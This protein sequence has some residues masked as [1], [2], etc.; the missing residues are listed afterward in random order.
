MSSD[1]NNF[2][3]IQTSTDEAANQLLPQFQMMLNTALDQQAAKY[4]NTMKQLAE[5]LKLFRMN[6]TQPPPAAAPSAPPKKTNQS[7]PPKKYD[8]RQTRR[9][10]AVATTLRQQNFRRA[11]SE[12][13]AS[14]CL[15]TTPKKIAPRGSLKNGSPSKRAPHQ[16]MLDD[17]PDDFLDTKASSIIFQ[18]KRIIE[19]ST[20]PPPANLEFVQQ[21]CSH[22]QDISAF[23]RHV[24]NSASAQL[25]A[26]TDVQTMKDA[27]A[28]RI[29]VGNNFVHIDETHIRYMHGY[30]AR[31]GIR[32]WGPNLEEGPESLFNSACRISAL[33]TFRQMA[34][35][36]G[37]DFMNF[38]HKYV[39]DMARFIN[40]YNHYVHHLS[41]HKFL[42]EI[43]Q[44]GKYKETVE[45]KNIA[46]NR[47]RVSI[48]ISSVHFMISVTNFIF[49]QLRDARYK[50]AVANNLPE[51]YR[52]IIKDTHANSDD[53]WDAEAKCFSIRTLPYR[54]YSANIFFRRL[55]DMMKN[56]KTN[57]NASRMRARKLPED[58]ILSKIVKIPKSLP[59]DFYNRSWLRKLPISQ[60]TTLPDITQVA[61][62]SDP[63]KS[64]LPKNNPRHDPSEKLS[65]RQFSK[66]RLQ[67]VLMTYRLDDVEEE[68]DDEAEVSEVD[69]ESEDQIDEC[70]AGDLEVG[71]SRHLADGD[72]ESYYKKDDTDNEEDEEYGDSDNH[73]EEMLDEEMDQDDGYENYGGHHLNDAEEEEIHDEDQMF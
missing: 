68:D 43:K 11:Q 65:D 20:P 53:E 73:E 1:N 52:K 23:E 17:Y 63:K 4:E 35:S 69:F 67:E 10:E 9:A 25:I 19:V 40:A 36:G 28:G 55:E 62:L 14:V 22:F 3:D 42:A 27:R 61:F 7:V 72:W 44:P 18:R 21:F 33:N 45:A 60:Q 13:L 38:N 56:S 49:P 57:T 50:F 5:E 24:N 8:T 6:S 15:V 31:I 54:S 41:S 48:Q 51:R 30:L 59:L 26:E 39:N 71:S 29:K 16:M 58:V 12:P 34:C 46:R 47:A 70:G 66:V 2:H 32:C 37:Y 64:L